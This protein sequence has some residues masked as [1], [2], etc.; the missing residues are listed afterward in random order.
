MKMRKLIAPSKPD[1]FS[2]ITD[3]SSVNWEFLRDAHLNV[4]C[5]KMFVFP[6]IHNCIRPYNQGCIKLKKGRERE[7]GRR[8]REGR[9][10]KGLGRKEGRREG[11]K[12]RG[13]ER[14][15]GREW[16]EK[17]KGREGKGEKQ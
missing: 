14:E 1:N 4:A 16:K 10:K 6:N 17:G 5:V 11:K 12:E 2:C 8:K 15:E 9:W 13:K 7:E 3:G